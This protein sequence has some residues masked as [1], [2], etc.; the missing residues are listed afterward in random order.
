MKGSI[1]SVALAGIIG[2]TGVAHATAGEIIARDTSDPLYL[3]G[4]EEIV[5]R[6]TVSYHDDILRFGQ[7]L[8]YGINNRLTLGGN[9]NYQH[10]FS[11]DDD[12]FSAVDLGGI[13]R[14]ARAQDNNSHIITD[15]IAGV[16]LGGSRHVRT[17]DYADSTFYA[18]LRFG[19]QWSAMTLA[20]TIKSSWIFDD[21]RGLSYIDMTPEAYFRITPDWRIGANFTLRKATDSAYNEEWIGGKIVREFGRTQYV[22]HVDYEFEHEETRVGA[23]VN[24]LF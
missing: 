11:G 2:M 4:I 19:R 10:D 13:Y 16:K 6:S 20:A 24:I 5:S 8:A 22:G 14:L 3:Q 12:G 15:V 17:P 23:K 21:D 18:G 9:I 1:F 7:T